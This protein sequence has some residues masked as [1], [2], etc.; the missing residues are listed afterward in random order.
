MSAR[1][2][3]LVGLV[4]T[5]IA[6]VYA[7][8]VAITR[9]EL[10]WGPVLQALIHVGELA[11]VVAIAVALGAR[12]GLVG[13]IGLG[14]AALGSVL[15]VVAEL[16]YPVNEPLGEQLFSVAPPL[17][18][19]GMVL[20]GIGVLRSGAWQGWHR[21]MPLLVGM[22]MFAVLTPAIILDGGPPAPASAFAL[23]GWD[24]CWALCAVA[25]LA[26]TSR[27]RTAVGQHV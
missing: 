6:V 18:G 24:L 17:S 3:A 4:L 2:A 21:F 15:L 12:A 7:S 8:F 13:R 11:I 25:V 10:S 14:I 19:L 23:A 5:A 1:N 26:E 27:A 16:A 9:V 20:A 22:W